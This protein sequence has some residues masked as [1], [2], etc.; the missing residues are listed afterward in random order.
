MVMLSSAY[1]DTNVAI[2]APFEYFGIVYGVVLGYL[3]WQEIP[4]PNMLLGTAFIVGS[5]LFIIYR[6]NQVA[7]NT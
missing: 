2:L 7:E 4:S 3:L 5:G 1:R 6:E